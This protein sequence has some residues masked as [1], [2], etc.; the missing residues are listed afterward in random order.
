MLLMKLLLR[1]HFFS[2][3]EQNLVVGI[4]W[5]WL[6]CHLHHLLASVDLIWIDLRVRRIYR[7]R[8]V[9]IAMMHVVGSILITLDWKGDLDDFRAIS[10]TLLLLVRKWLILIHLRSLSPNSWPIPLLYNFSFFTQILLVFLRLKQLIF[11][12]EQVRIVTI[13]DLPIEI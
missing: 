11:I 6:W 8:V 2:H 9:Y 5:L 4:C 10:C 1:W 13:L 7:R 12:G 3:M